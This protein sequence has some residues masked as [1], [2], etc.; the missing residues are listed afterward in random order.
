MCEQTFTKIMLCSPDINFS[1]E[2]ANNST[3]LQQIQVYFQ[4]LSFQNKIQALSQDS[5]NQQ[6]KENLN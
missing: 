3:L 5:D 4:T 6:R 2:F 1:K